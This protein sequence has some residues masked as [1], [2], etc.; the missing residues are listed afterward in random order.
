[1]NILIAMIGTRGDVQPYVALG[2]GLKAA[3]HDVTVCT[4]VRFE[5]FVRQHGLDYAYLNDDLVA[6]LD[7]MEGRGA[8]EDMGSFLS[9]IKAGLKLLKR[10][11]PIMRSIIHD[12]WAATRAPEPDL[13]VYHSK[14]GTAPHYA[15]ELGL[16]VVLAM[17]FPQFVP[18][19]AY[20]SIGFPKLASLPARLQAWYN[21]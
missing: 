8:V 14:M 9:G 16:P 12:G 19:A 10:T 7:T 20:P 17:T 15:D 1:M 21:R 18:T 11:G 2:Q 4:S 13:I 5:P 6:L 3:G